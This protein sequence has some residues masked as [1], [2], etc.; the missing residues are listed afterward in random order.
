MLPFQ[1]LPTFICGATSIDK[2]RSR[3]YFEEGS[4]KALSIWISVRG[5]S[6]LPE[7]FVTQTLESEFHA[8][9]VSLYETA[10]GEG[11]YEIPSGERGKTSMLNLEGPKYIPFVRFI[12]HYVCFQGHRKT[13]SVWIFVRSSC[14]PSGAEASWSESYVPRISR[15]KACGANMSLN[16][17][18]ERVLDFLT[19]SQV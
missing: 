11:V 3:V 8:L 15:S 18:N 16:K 9:T 19:F 1:E 10:S 14:N 17:E 2:Q 4:I 6:I 5:A 7:F 12:S 13:F